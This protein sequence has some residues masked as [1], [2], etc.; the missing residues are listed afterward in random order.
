MPKVTDTAATEPAELSEAERWALYLAENGYSVFPVKPNAKQPHAGFKWRERSTADLDVVRAMIRRYP[1]SNW[2][3]DCDKSKLLV[4]DLDVKGGIDGITNWVGMTADL[5]QT[6]PLVVRTPSNGEHRYYRDD[7]GTIGNQVSKVTPGVDVRGPGGYVLT[8]GS[9]ID[10]NAYK[11]SPDDA[12]RLGRPD[13]LPGLTED[14]RALLSSP[15]RHDGPTTGTGETSPRSDDPSRAYARAGV[16]TAP[17]GTVSKREPLGAAGVTSAVALELVRLANAP[18]GQRNNVLNTAAYN[19]G[20]LAHSPAIAEGVVRDALVQTALA[21]GLESREALDTV[22]SGWEN[23]QAAPRPVKGAKTAD[24]QRS[25]VALYEPLDLDTWYSEPHPSP[26]H[27]GAGGVL[28]EGALTWLQGEP[29]SGKSVL[30]LQWA[31]D[32]ARTGRGVVWL[33]EEAGPADTLAKLAA[34]G[35]TAEDLT[36]RF[37]YLPPLGRNLSETAEQ[38]HA[39]VQSGDVGLVVVDSSAAVLANAGVDED[40]NGPVA[41]FVNQTLL[42]IA[43][44][45]GVA[46]VVID[47]KTKSNPDSRYARGASA[48]L[49]IVDLALDVV[50]RQPFSKEESGLLELIVQKDRWGDHGRGATWQVTVTTGG[51]QMDLDFAR[52]SR[53]ETQA[54][55]PAT[56]AEAAGALVTQVAVRVRTA[57]PEG[58]SRNQLERTFIGTGVGTGKVREAVRAA[59]EAGLIREGGKVGAGGAFPLVAT[60]GDLA[61]AVG[62]PF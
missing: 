10:G 16:P 20:Q 57:G 51:G 50:A 36:G 19:I 62:E 33:D 6:V 8:P 52:L 32:V 45:F 44:Q 2:A 41:Q 55:R 24:E 58:L 26:A 59:E 25:A 21:V 42:P 12:A 17:T 43:K 28:Y 46:V 27:L 13:A 23:G 47:H 40:R 53:E 34:L 5:T 56:K 54:R 30:A 9:V 4:I 61:V 15:K 3:I 11:L 29:E 7:D 14:L 38:F 18:E 49:G 48:K 37:R 1:C 35:G 39:L 22:K 31:L 60:D